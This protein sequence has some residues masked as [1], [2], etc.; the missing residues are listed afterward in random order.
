M[1]HRLRRVSEQHRANVLCREEVRQDRGAQRIDLRR[2][3]HQRALAA[4]PRL[5]GRWTRAQL[6]V[7]YFKCRELHSPPSF[8]SLRVGLCLGRHSRPPP[9]DVREPLAAD[10]V[11]GQRGVPDPEEGVADGFEERINL[12]HVVAGPQAGARKSR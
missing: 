11:C 6:T 8:T 12:L 5:T 4:L 2:N 3:D 10:L 1:R 9:K 7:L